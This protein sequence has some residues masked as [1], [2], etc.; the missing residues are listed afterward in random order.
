MYNMQSAFKQKVTADIYQCIREENYCQSF[1][2]CY[3]FTFSVE[4]RT[5]V[6]YSFKPKETHTKKLPKISKNQR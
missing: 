3:V 5:E 1:M 2:D 6:Y 4:N